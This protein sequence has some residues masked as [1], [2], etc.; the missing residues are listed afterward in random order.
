MQVIET[1]AIP[2]GDAPLGEEQQQQA[3]NAI[4]N[5]KVIFLPQLTFKLTALEQRFLSPNYVDPKAKNISFDIHS[6]TLCGVQGSPNDKQ[7]LQAMMKRFAIQ[8][9]QLVEHLFPHYQTALEQARTSF[10][11]VQVSDRKTSYRKDDKRLHVDAFPATPNQ[12]KRI[13]RV[14]SNIN[15]QGEDRVWRVGE[16][17]ENVAK[18][19]LPQIS[20]PPPGS[21]KLLKLL[22][23]T[24]SYRT[25]YDHIMLQI[26]DRMKA[27]E[28][29]QQQAQQCEVRFPPNTTWIVQTD[30]VSHAAMSG[31][32]LLEQ[33]FYLPVTA[34]QDP[35]RSPLRILEKLTSRSLI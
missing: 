25:H 23:I 5:G 30:Q 22:K 20:N 35:Q 34:M 8:A 19:F 31:Q 18:R 11:P 6:H 26:H 32:Y 2:H 1:L 7:Q 29:Y 3:I 28:T 15:P 21:A 27:D 9:R 13:L 14:F 16:P 33:T 4:E 12:G 24:K 10:R 17:F